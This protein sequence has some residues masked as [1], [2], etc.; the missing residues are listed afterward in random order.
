M[1][2]LSALLVMFLLIAAPASAQVTASFGYDEVEFYFDKPKDEVSYFETN[3]TL[4]FSNADNESAAMVSNLEAKL[5]GEAVDKGM[6]VTLEKTSLRIEPEDSSYLLI[7]FRAPPGVAEGSYDAKLEVKGD[8]TYL[9]KGG[10]YSLLREFHITVRIEHPPPTLEATWDLAEWGK[11]RAGQSFERTLTVREIYGYAGA[12]NVTLYLSRRGPVNLTHPQDIGDIP[13]GG[14]KSVKVKIQ[15]PERHLRPGDYWVAPRIVGEYPAEVATREQANYTIPRPEMKLSSTRINFGRITFEVGKDAA[16]ASIIVSET[17]GYTPIEGLKISQV[18][19]EEGWVAPSRID[20]IPPG[21]NATLNFT[22]LLPPDASLGKKIWIFSIAAGYAGSAEILGKATVYFPGLEEAERSLDKVPSLPYPEARDVVQNLRGLVMGAKEATELREIA[23]VMSVYS[24]A[25]SFLN[26]LAGAE[27][28]D[29][30][31]ERIILARGSLNRAKI[32]SEGLEDKNLRK[33]AI[34]V[35]EALEEVWSREARN[36]GRA[37]EKEIEERGDYR[38]AVLDYKKLKT[39]YLYLGDAE[40]AKEYATKQEEMERAYFNALS[41][42]MSLLKASE[43]EMEAAKGLSF[44]IKE[45]SIVV[46]PF[47]YER[48]VAHYQKAISSVERAKILLERA[49]EGEE[50]ELLQVKLE[51]LRKG[52]RTLEG[53]FRGYLGLLTL[54][55][56]WFVARATLGLLRW[57]RD[58]EALAEGDVLLGGEG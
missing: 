38:S 47:H 16:T 8:Y 5:Y 24:G 53:I 54:F 50:A 40:K 10:S 57:V 13:A 17:G 43:Q 41:E 48:V 33:Y 46:N 49:G 2:A 20:Y 32:G 23:M 36:A 51:E 14:S 52:K 34:P 15:V 6:S 12:S 35:V 45:V 30:R 22:L 1:R 31:V 7:S 58:S 11:L 19:G 28:K 56:L 44:N 42:A 39:L 25:T 18:K 27:G 55:F 3:L 21:G 4:W 29:E 9:T 37:L 26:I